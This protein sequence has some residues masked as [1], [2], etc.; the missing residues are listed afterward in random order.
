MVFPIVMYGYESWTIKKAEHW[1][2][3]AFELWCWRR[4]PWTATRSNQSILKEIN[5]EYSLGGLILK[6]QHF[7]HLMWRAIS[8][9]RPWYWERLKAGGERG[10]RGWDGSMSSSTQWT[11][12]W[13]KFRRQWR[14][15][16]PSVLQSIRSQRVGHNWATEQ[17]HGYLIHIEHWLMAM[18]LGSP[19]HP[20][21]TVYN[22]VAEA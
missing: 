22:P 13:V 20:T 15:G 11:W 8:L 7:G 19:L 16:N 6:L 1:R 4:V 2:I 21:T 14:T 5:P 9:E 3:D 10:T 12:V 17:Q 18:L